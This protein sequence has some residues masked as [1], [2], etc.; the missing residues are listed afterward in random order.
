MD[1]GDAVRA[2]KAGHRVA[3]N[4]WNGKGMWIAMVAGVTTVMHKPTPVRPREEGFSA[5]VPSDRVHIEPHVVMKTADNKLIP[6]LC[7]QT[8]LL[9]EDWGVL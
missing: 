6:W 5:S 1:I 2:M 7:S 8:D 9:A 4:G 3:R